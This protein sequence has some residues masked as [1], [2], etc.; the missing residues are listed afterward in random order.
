MTTLGAI[1]FVFCFLLIVL[2]L[3]MPVM[4]TIG[5]GNR[6]STLEQATF[7]FTISGL[8]LHF[9]TWGVGAISFTPGTMAFVFG[10]AAIFAV[11]GV[12]RLPWESVRQWISREK[13]SIH[14]DPW[15]GVLLIVLAGLALTTAV[16]GLAP[17]ADYDGLN[18]HL[19]LPKRDFEMGRIVPVPG[20][21]WQEYFPALMEMLYRLA[22]ALANERAAQMVHGLYG[23]AAAAATLCLA[24][25]MGFGLSTGRLAA[26]MYL[27]IR[28]V[29][30]EAGTSHNELALAAYTALALIA[31]LEWRSRED[32]RSMLLFGLMIGGMNLTKYVALPLMG[33]FGLI[34]L[35]DLVIRRRPP[36][37]AAIGFLVALVVFSPLLVR[38]FAEAGNPVMPLFHDY[39][40]WLFH[41]MEP[42]TGVLI[43]P[44]EDPTIGSVIV[45]LL[46]LPWDIFVD[47]SRFMGGQQFGAP[48]LLMFAPL[49]LLTRGKGSNLWLVAALPL[50]FFIPWY[51]FIAQDI[52]HLAAVF[53][54]LAALA[55]CGAAE[56]WPRVRER[57]MTTTIAV[58]LMLLVF[59]NQSMFVGVYALVR[60]PVILGAVDEVTY[61]TQVPTMNVNIYLSCQHLTNA[62]RPGERYL[63]FL[64][65]KSFYCPQASAI[66][67]VFDEERHPALLLFS[68]K[69]KLPLLSATD[70]GQRLS[71]DNVRFVL[72]P[73]RFEE[74]Q[75]SATWEVRADYW[76]R[77]RFG[78][79]VAPIID[80]MTPIYSGPDAE[81][82]GAAP[83]IAAL[84]G[85]P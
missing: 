63:S 70:L 36:W 2:G 1:G 53:P 77:S 21:A 58:A 62:I 29:V 66:Y 16:A 52:R 71:R 73:T 9:A 7:A 50:A 81:V 22:F 19:T 15:R 45:S 23:L 60:G 27:S 54:M 14:S 33:C 65:M 32:I 76:K 38:N 25:R 72:V 17:P 24:R 5:R 43:L 11:P 20:D 67:N 56:L 30:W 85:S 83:L 74:R 49:V 59:V 75:G 48:Y 3:G 10:G 40:Q 35:V 69:K 79:L 82:Y 34:M 37:H 18:Y 47:P 6:F 57:A 26:V 55:A 51:L 41:G 78:P 31:Y 28:N 13:V 8:V 46:R 80:D 84:M 4:A 61:V 68:R 39:F 42:S 12:C 44:G 64:A